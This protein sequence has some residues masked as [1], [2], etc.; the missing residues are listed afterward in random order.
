L[1][2]RHGSGVLWPLRQTPSVGPTSSR[3]LVAVPQQGRNK[4]AK[5]FSPCRDGACERRRV[6]KILCAMLRPLIREIREIFTTFNVAWLKTPLPPFPPPNAFGAPNPVFRFC[7]FGAVQILRF[8][9]FP[10]RPSVQNPLPFPLRLMRARR[11]LP[12]RPSRG[13]FL[14][15]R[16]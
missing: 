4:S 12:I 7:H 15:G 10:W 16:P 1:T 5:H 3:P 13:P 6:R 11:F 2:Y 14:T 8:P 9:S